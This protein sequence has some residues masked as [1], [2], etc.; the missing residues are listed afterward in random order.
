VAFDWL[1]GWAAGPR[2]TSTRTRRRSP[3]RGTDRPGPVLIEI[4]VTVAQHEAYARERAG[5]LRLLSSAVFV[6]ATPSCAP[7]RC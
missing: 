7:G 2:A 4:A 3:D 1:T 6:H 5:S